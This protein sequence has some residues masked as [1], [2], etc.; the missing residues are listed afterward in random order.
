MDEPTPKTGTNRAHFVVCSALVLIAAALMY[1]YGTIKGGALSGNVVV[2][3]GCIEWRGPNALLAACAA[4]LALAAWIG[5]TLWRQRRI[6]PP[7]ERQWTKPQT[8]A[9]LLS[10]CLAIAVESYVTALFL[11]GLC[12]W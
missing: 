3:D 10:L 11:R 4:T 8:R 9:I 2:E 7:A 1:R 12:D 5:W 6:S